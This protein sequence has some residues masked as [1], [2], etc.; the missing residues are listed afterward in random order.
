M[1]ERGTVRGIVRLWIERDDAPGVPREPT[2]LYLVIGDDLPE[3]SGAK[4]RAYGT[5][6][7]AQDAARLG[8]WQD[9]LARRKLNIERYARG[10]TFH[11]DLAVPKALI[12]AY[13]MEEERNAESRT[14]D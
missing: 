7:R 10:R 9:L 14:G 6:I 8:A 1:P 3:R 2:N 5:S 4:T 13:D 12:D 11:A